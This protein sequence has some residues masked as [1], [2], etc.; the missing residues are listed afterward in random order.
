MSYE[1]PNVVETTNTT[2]IAEPASVEKHQ[3]EISETVVPAKQTPQTTINDNSI[4]PTNSK[5]KKKFVIGTEES[6]RGNNDTTSDTE[7]HINS[8]ETVENNLDTN[9]KQKIESEDEEGYVNIPT[10]PTQITSEPQ[11]QQPTQQPTPKEDKVGELN[12]PELSKPIMS[13]ADSVKVE[14]GSWNPANIVTNTTVTAMTQRQSTPTKQSP[15][16]ILNTPADSPDSTPISSQSPIA[17]DGIVNAS[18]VNPSG[19]NSIQP[20]NMSDNNYVVS[21][22]PDDSYTSEPLNYPHQPRFPPSSSG[23]S[24]TQQKLLLQRQHFLADDENYLIHP[25]NQLRLTKVIER[26]NREHAAISLFRDPIIESLQRVWPKYV[27]DHPEV[28]GDDF[29]VGYEDVKEWGVISDHGKSVDHIGSN[30]IISTE[31]LG[32]DSM[33]LRGLK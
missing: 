12:L 30:S 3:T 23:M 14:L 26:I 7:I 9:N 31:T 21:Q 15:K 13:P 6:N 25:R 10:T 29:G 8:K 2:E 19:Q 28:L 16:F 5:T 4:A 17:S 33:P 1:E 11:P 18:F 27:Q 20:I 24:R 22:P 32:V